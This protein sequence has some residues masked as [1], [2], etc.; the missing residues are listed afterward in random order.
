MHPLCLFSVVGVL[1]LV[2]IYCHAYVPRVVKVKQVVPFLHAT[3]TDADK[4][5]MPCQGC[6]IGAERGAGAGMP[7]VS[8]CLDCHCHVLADD[9]RLLPVHA[10]ANMDAPIYTGEPLGWKLSTP[11]PAHVHFHHARH[12]QAGISCA[13]CHPSP[14]APVQHTMSS[15]LDCHRKHALPTDCDACHH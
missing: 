12:A 1:T 11:L 15:C 10:A 7:P 3:H 13:E 5:N 4:V 8:V 6:H 14:D 2:L 9:T